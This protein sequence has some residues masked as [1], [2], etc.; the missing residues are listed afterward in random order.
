MASRK[1]TDK[2]IEPKE[3][4]HV[5]NKRKI[6]VTPEFL[7]EV[8]QLSGQGFTNENLAYFYGVAV[9]TWCEYKKNYP[10]I[11]EAIK[12]GK[13][14]CL[15]I[16]TSVMWEGVKAKD[17]AW[18]MF[19]LKT[20]WKFSEHA[21]MDIKKEEVEKSITELKIT[22]TDP[23]EASRIYQQIMTTGS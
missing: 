22:T 18:T 16:A 9:G 3:R 23:I 7:A 19:Y 10:E 11:E 8:G 1:K 2:P 13:I 17:K 4:K 5:T 20:Q 21:T 12:Y 6:E 14:K 15:E